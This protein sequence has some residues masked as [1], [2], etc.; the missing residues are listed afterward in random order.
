MKVRTAVRTLTAATLVAA[1]GTLALTAP[2]LAGGADVV[3]A[4]T[5]WDYALPEGGTARV[6]SVATPS[7]R[8][9]V[10][11]TV[12][13][14]APGKVYG[15]HAHV[16]ACGSLPTAAG[17]HWQREVDPVQPSVDP[18]YANP[19]N[20]VWLDVTTD[21]TGAGTAT[22]ALDYAFPSQRAPRS[23]IIHARATSTGSDGT[24]AA[25]TAGARLAC[26]D[27]AF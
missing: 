15:A 16:A 25:G 26:V 23:V 10:T 27:V 17:G 6:Q 21:E 3:R 22:A 19:A 2:A 24:G 9:L 7:G 20:E 5:V 14:M 12:K 8:T 1:G 4:G 13:G 18:A 11:L